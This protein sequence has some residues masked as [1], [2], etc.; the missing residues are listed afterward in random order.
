MLVAPRA[1]ATRRNACSPSSGAARSWSHS[2]PRAPRRRARRGH[3]A[4]TTASAGAV[5]DARDGFVTG[6][7]RGRSPDSEK[8]L[9]LTANAHDAAMYAKTRGM[10][11]RCRW[12][13][14]HVAAQVHYLSLS[15]ARA[16]FPHVPMTFAPPCAL[17]YAVL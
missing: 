13:V 4:V 10:A 17:P 9:Y 7:V 8:L 14:F 11:L 12:N 6:L 3:E 5:P 1:A 2:A 16:P 15:F